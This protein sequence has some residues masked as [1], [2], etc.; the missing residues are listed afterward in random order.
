MLRDLHIRDYALLEDARLELGEGLNCLTGET[1]VGKSLVLGALDLLLG[2]RARPDLVRAGAEGLQVEGR[3]EVDSPRL[4]A[5]VS[6]RLGFPLEDGVAEILLERRYFVGSRNL[7][8]VNGRPVNVAVLRAVGERLVDIH[9]QH[10]HESL[11]HPANQRD[12]L[13]GFGRLD[14]LR[15]RFAQRHRDLKALRDRAAQLQAGED[16]RRQRHE[17]LDFQYAEARALAP[18]EG[19]YADLRRERDLLTNAERLHQ[20][21][22]EGL[23]SLYER[24]GSSIE[25]IQRLHRDL[26]SLA[27][28]Q[29]DLGCA[30]TALA[31]AAAQVEEAARALRRFRESFEFDPA[32]LEEVEARL[33]L[34]QRIAQRHGVQPNEVHALLARL[35]EETAR[36]D[37]GDRDLAAVEPLIRAA[38]AEM[39]EIGEELSRRRREA[40]DD[41]AA[42]V[43]AELRDLAMPAARFGVEVTSAA[44]EAGDA[45]GPGGFDTVEFL[46]TTN[47]G[48]A[49][50]PLRSVGSGGEV[51]RVMLAIK[52]CLAEVDRTPVF[53]FDEIDANV[54]GRLGGVIG[55]K[56]SAIA[57]KHQVVCITHLPQIAA[58]AD[59]HLKV[60]KMTRNG[61]TFSHVA[62]LRGDARVE[63]LAEMIHGEKRTD[64]TRRQAREMLDAAREAP[65]EPEASQPRRHARSRS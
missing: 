4:L 47:P 14:D 24:E 44:D 1:G 13:D 54:G 20:V 55:R 6:E 51:S 43:E 62:S 53:V 33:A 7:C 49:P 48:E 58:W 11:L 60:S 19:E 2:G 25:T 3:V 64:T 46:I 8:R 16:L 27:G 9:G 63:E 40:G 65:A 35:A 61:R 21:T 31:E 5:D 36:L 26:E 18:R 45:P 34:Y 37:A 57:R 42:R 32:R 29:R 38:S 41:L 17:L 28:A 52:G 10:E 30:V 50:R 59:A 56:L 15:R 23:E 12:L 39:R 22:A